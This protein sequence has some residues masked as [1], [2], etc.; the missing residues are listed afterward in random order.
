MRIAYILSTT[1]V[2]SGS[3]IAFKNMLRGVMER[4]VEPIVII[5]D[6]QELYDDLKPL[7]IPIFMTTY[8]FNVYPYLNTLKDY[9][10]FIPKLVARQVVNF[11][12]VRKLTRYLRDKDIDIIHTNIGVM[13]V[14]F[15]TAKRLKIPHIYHIREYGDLDFGLHYFPNKKSFIKQLRSPNSYSISITK[16]IRRYFNEKGRMSSRI[17]YDGVF[18]QK[19]ELVNKPKDR[20]FLYVGRIQPTKGLMPL[21]EAYNIF[22]KTCPVMVPLH[23]IGGITDEHFHQQVLHFIEENKLSN[24]VFFEGQISD[25]SHWMQK[26]LAIIIPSLSEGFGFCMP[27]AMFNGC[28]AIGYNVGGTKEQMDNGLELQG[29]EIALRYDNI[30]ELVEHLKNVASTAPEEYNPYILRAFD[31]VNLLYSMEHHADQVYLFYQDILNNTLSAHGK[32]ANKKN[33]NHFTNGH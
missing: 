9:L 16:G 25:V 7:D 29:K 8:R 31:T 12:A 19:N 1:P 32:F 21:L 4:G 23:V 22:C 33:K 26:A 27:E 30:T 20:F 13:D 3:H 14:G 2:L 10:V 17:I 24:S 6:K 11:I 18:S 15:R 5:P 28:L